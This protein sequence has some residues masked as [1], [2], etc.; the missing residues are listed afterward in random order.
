[1]QNRY[2]GDIGDF[3]KLG[4]LRS[5]Q[6]AGMKIGVNWYLIPDETHNNDG[7]HIEYLNQ[8]NYKYC[9]KELYL[10]LKEIVENSQ[11][12]VK[13]LE[14]SHILEA[15]FFSD[16]LDFKEKTKLERNKIRQ[17][18][19]RKALNKLAKT[20]IVFVDPDNGLI[21]PSAYNTTKENKYVLNNEL[22]DYYAQKS[23]VIYYQHKARRKDEFY[24]HQHARL[25]HSGCFPNAHGFALKF[26]KTSH[27]Y[28]FFIIQ[29]QHK[30]VIEKAISHMLNTPWKEY[31]KFIT[32]D[33]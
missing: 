32:C 28:Y 7:R 19:H 23:S 6:Y 10:E 14:N 20:D 33:E 9:D 17:E 16:S 31:F 26:T 29:P 1:M 25:I 21:V 12:K 18:W 30:I 4:M 5:L 24:I 2:T 13:Y 8:D 15:G 27:R 22:A 11:R 3:G